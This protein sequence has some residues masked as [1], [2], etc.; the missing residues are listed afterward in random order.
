MGCENITA[1]INTSILCQLRI[2]KDLPGDEV[3]AAQCYL[4]TCQGACAQDPVL[5]GPGDANMCTVALDT[6]CKGSNVE[7]LYALQLTWICP[8]S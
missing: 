5:R 8:A 2:N 4:C 3:L 7:Q 6:A 1:E